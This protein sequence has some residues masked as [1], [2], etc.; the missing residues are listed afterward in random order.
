MAH[1][2]DWLP[3]VAELCQVNLPKA[4]INGKSLMPIIRSANAP[5]PHETLH[6]Q[7]GKNRWAVRNGNWK[8]T[9]ENGLF[10][11]N[12]LDDPGEKINL[13]QKNPEI[14]NKL[15]TMRESIK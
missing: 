5:S 3:T 7:M 2:C 10:L 4:P 11:A 8:L 1:G 6:W 12:I 13:S 15:K 9:S 14:V